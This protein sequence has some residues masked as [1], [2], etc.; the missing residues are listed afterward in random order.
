MGG[1]FIN[2]ASFGKL[3]FLSQKRLKMD[4]EIE[5]KARGEREVDIIIQWTLGCKKS[6]IRIPYKH[7]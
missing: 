6:T 7:N 4:T 3:L 2:I 5:R 1:K